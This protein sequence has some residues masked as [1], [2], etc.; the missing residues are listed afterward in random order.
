MSR[1]TIEREVAGLLKEQILLDSDR[2]VAFDAPSGR[3]SGWIRWDLWN[4]LRRS[5][6]NSTSNSP[7]VSGPTAGSSR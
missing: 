1:D 3:V 7:I 2:E 4:F 5:R 6:R